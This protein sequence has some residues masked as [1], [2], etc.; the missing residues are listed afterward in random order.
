MIGGAILPSVLHQVPLGTYLGWNITASGFFKG[1]VC[2]F[3]GGYVPF[4]KTKAQRLAS[5]DPRLSLEERY[6][7]QEGYVAAVRIAAE[8]AVR[9]RFLHKAKHYAQQNH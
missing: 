3:A 4:A 5:Q 1:Q 6:G 7:N 2:A 8:K 9:A